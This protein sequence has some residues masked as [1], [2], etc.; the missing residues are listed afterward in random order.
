MKF[1]LTTVL[2]TALT[3]STTVTATTVPQTDINKCKKKNAHAV[4]AIDTFCLMSNIVVPGTYA[5]KGFHIGTGG[6]RDTTVYIAGNC[7]PGQWVPRSICRAQFY[8]MCANSADG[9]H[10]DSVANYGRN[11]CQEWFINVKGAYA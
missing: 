11:G 10:G 3:A 7:K 6:P 5:T 4:T 2:L 1:T 8:S 9:S